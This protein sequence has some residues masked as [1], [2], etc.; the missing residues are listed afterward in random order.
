MRTDL[1]VGRHRHAAGYATVI[2][3]GCLEEA[4]FAGRFIAYPGDVLLHGAFDCHANRCLTRTPLQI[5][6]LPWDENL[7]EGRFCVRDPDVLAAMTE[8]DPDEA[9]RQL[10]LELK[11][12]PTEQ[13]HWTELLANILRS[14]SRV[15]L[16]EWAETNRLSPETVSRGFRR[17]FGV[18][19]KLFRVESR[20]RRAWNLLTNCSKS[21]TDVAYEEGFADLA[22]L[23]RNIAALTGASPSYWRRQSFSGCLAYQMRSISQHREVAH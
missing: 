18:S 22:H 16:E 21:L 11:S 2:L 5:L 15:R 23:S 19:P 1:I 4:S 14:G 6:R 10:R 12:V 7:I 17:V 8:R 9:S 3:S 20:A 13:A